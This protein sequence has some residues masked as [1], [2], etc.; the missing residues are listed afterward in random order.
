MAE[1]PAEFDLRIALGSMRCRTCGFQC[2]LSFLFK[3]IENLKKE[4]AK[5]KTGS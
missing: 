4:V 2:L 5:F 1:C 3:E